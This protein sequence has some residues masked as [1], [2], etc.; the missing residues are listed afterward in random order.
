[1][2]ALIK[3]VYKQ[4]I[5]INSA[6][7]F[8]RSVFYATYN[9]YLMKSQAYNPGNKLKTFTDIKNNDGRA[10]SLHYKISFAAG[11]FID[12]L[13]HKI[14]CP[15]DNLG[16]PITFDIA[17]FELLESDI[18]DMTAHKIAINYI[19]DT[20]A[21]HSVVGEFLLLSEGGISEV[22]NAETF[23]LKMQV[24]LSII[25]YQEIEEKPHY[26]FTERNPYNNN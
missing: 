6:S 9:E 25:D 5:D 18:I 7:D 10:N 26:E 21:F 17:K 16:N 1:M 13:N 2:K 20:H 23:M 3:L 11:H 4:V 8:E 19:T 12:A 15:A 24:N 14:P 22:K